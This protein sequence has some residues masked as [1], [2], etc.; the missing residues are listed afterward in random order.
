MNSQRTNSPVKKWANVLSRQ[1]SK[2]EVQKAKKYT[3]K[4]STSLSIKE[5][6]I[7]PAWRFHI[8]LVRMA[9]VK[10]R[11]SNAVEQPLLLGL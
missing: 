3:K 11:N 1:N 4:S 5:M 7:K 6:Q 10:N 8:T 9:G 2:E